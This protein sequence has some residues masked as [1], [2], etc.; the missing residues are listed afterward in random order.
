MFHL[1]VIGITCSRTTSFE[2]FKLSASFG[3]SGSSAN[4]RIAGSIPLVETVIRV[5]GIPISR[6]SSRTAS[7]NAS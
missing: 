3:R 4:R 7:M 2:A 6:L 5:T 1:R